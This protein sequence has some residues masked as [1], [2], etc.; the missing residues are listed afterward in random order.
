MTQ[1]N[2][3]N[4]FLDYDQATLDRNYNQGAWAANAD[5]IIGWYRTAS[6]AAH[7]RLRCHAALAYGPGALERLDLFP[8]DRPGAPVVIYVHGGAWR[9]MTGMDS[10]F[11]AEMFVGAG[12]NFV[13]LDFASIPDARLPEMVA[14]VRRGIGWVARHAADF[15]CDPEQLFV[16]GHSSGAHLVAA[17]L[18][19]AWHDDAIAA[20]AVKAAMCASGSYDLAP[21]MLSARGSYLQLSAD[22][23]QAFSPMRHLSHVSCPV[24]VAYGSD[25]TDEFQRHARELH[26]GLLA[27]GKSSELIYAEG[28]N[29]FEISQTLAEPDGILARA[30]LRMIGVAQ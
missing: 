16:I 2:T 3:A 27:A 23:E 22:E 6:L 17:A 9:T 28:Y 12:I 5:Q 24:T 8:A 11:A 14:Q 21:V 30:A 1:P 7:A 15:G 20:S 18:T 26:A 10:A 13:V 19:T 25:E 29:H 4:V